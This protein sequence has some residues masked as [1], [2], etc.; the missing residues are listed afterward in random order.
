MPLD[1]RPSFQNLRNRILTIC[2]GLLILIGS[3][4]IIG[5]LTN[6]PTLLQISHDY[7]PIRMNA[8]LGFILTGLGLIGIALN[9]KNL[10]LSTGII[11]ILMGYLTLMQYILGI[12]FGID[13]L[14]IKSYLHLGTLP[15]GRP[16]PQVALSQILAGVAFILMPWRRQRQTIAVFIAI[17]ALI[18]FC[19]GLLSTMGYVVGIKP[20]YGWGLLTQVSL[21]VAFGLIILGLGLNAPVWPK[22]PTGRVNVQKVRNSILAYT[23]IGAFTIAILAGVTAAMPIYVKFEKIERQDMQIFLRDKVLAIE[24][25]LNGYKEISI[26]IGNETNRVDLLEDL[27]IGKISLKTYREA[28]EGILKDALQFSKMLKGIIILDSKGEVIISKGARIPKEWWPNFATTKIGTNWGEIQIFDGRPFGVVSNPILGRKGDHIGTDLILFSLHDIIPLFQPMKEGWKKK[29]SLSLGSIDMKGK[30]KL[31]TTSPEKPLSI[32][33]IVKPEPTQQIAVEKALKGETSILDSSEP[34]KRP[35]IVAFTPIPGTLWGALLTLPTEEFYFDVNK[36]FIII[37]SLV[38]IFGLVGSLGTLIFLR[39]LAGG[40]ILH[41]SELERQIEDAKQA[42]KT[43]SGLIPICSICRKIREDDGYWKSLE[44]Y[45]A[46]HTEAMLSHGICQDCMKTNYPEE[47]AQI[48]PENKIKPTTK[49][50]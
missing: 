28:M 21:L 50:E 44:E 34:S 43:L 13:Q 33:E 30:I 42:I 16:P 18:I 24:N 48:Y 35:L 12:D 14:F 31:I 17:I 23:S 15:P 4:G 7:P 6:S 19:T 36:A 2:G 37:F 46:T 32:H 20:T 10:S 47:Y 25:L 49:P 40:I 26:Q 39:P 9:I 1:I 45:I 22:K 5:W 8:A 11:I 3:L 41:A 38:L 27:E 29:E